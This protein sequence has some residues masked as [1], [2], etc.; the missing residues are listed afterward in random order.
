MQ[1]VARHNFTTVKTE[2]AILPADLLQRIAGGKMEG[3]QPA[4]YHLGP[5]ERL[6]D[7]ITRAW[8]RCQ[9]VW[10]TFNDQRGQLAESDSGLSLTRERW[11]LILFQELGYGRLAYQPRG[12]EVS[13]RSSVIGNQPP[14]TD[15]R[16][17]ITDPRYPISHLWQHTPI[18][19]VS[20]RQ[21]LDRRDPAIKRSPH[22]LM[23][24]FL[25][26]SEDHLWGF[27]SNGLTLQILRDNASLTRAAYVEFD[28]EKMMTEQV[29]ADFTLLWL[30]CHQSR[31]EIRAADGQSPISNLQSPANCWL[32]KWSQ[33]AAEQGTRALD[34]LRIG[35]Q[36]AI[37]ALGRGFLAHPGNETLKRSLRAG[38]LSRDDYFRQ[39]LRLVYRLI[40]L[41]V[42]EE[43]DL[44]LLP[45]ADEPARARY[46]RYYSTGR[47]R[48]LAEAR[49]G[50]PHPD[51][52]RTLRQVFGLLRAGY[53]EL[54]LPA[55][56]SFL[57]SERSTPA[58]DECDLANHDLLNAIRAL[59]LTVEGQ[60]TRPVDYKN[61]GAEELGSV[62]ESLLELHPF[63][64]IEAA[65]FSLD[66][67]AG[68]ERKT[69]GSYY[70]PSSLINSLLDTALEPVVADRLQVAGGKSQVGLA[71]EGAILSIKVV[72]PACGSGHFLMAAA[73]RLATH[74]ARVRTGDGEPS[75]TARREALRDVVHHCIHG[76]DIN[77]MAVELCKVGLWMETLDPGK[78][79]GFLERN[80]QCGNSLIGATPALLRQGIPDAAFTPI[81]GDDTAFCTE[82]K[83]RN[84]KEREG[85]MSMRFGEEPWQRLGD[86]AA[87]MAQLDSMGDRTLDEVRAQE[88][89]Y[90]RMLLSSSYE[91]SHFWADSWC[92]AF[93]WPKNNSFD[94]P[95]TEQ[96]FRKIERDPF[97]VVPWMKM[98][99]RRLRDEYKFFHWH[100]VFPH[101][102]TPRR[103]DPKGSSQNPTGLND[104]GV[105]G[106]TEGFD[107]VLGNPP[108]EKI[109]AEEQ[110]F[111]APESPD[112]A[113]AVGAKRKAMIQK[114][115]KTDPAL[116]HRWQSYQESIKRVDTFFKVSRR[117]PLTGKGKLNTYAVFSELAL[118]IQRGIG[119]AGIII[120]LGIV[121]DYTT[122]DFFWHLMKQKRIKKLIGFE[123]ESFI[124]PDVHHS[125]KFTILIM[126]G[127]ERTEPEPD[128]VFFCRSVDDVRDASRHFRLTADDIE[129]L[130][131]NTHNC[132]IFRSER[133]FRIVQDVY[134]QHPIIDSDRIGGPWG[135]RIHRVV[136]PTDDS[137]MMQEWY[138]VPTRKHIIVEDGEFWAPV[139]EAK[140]IHQFDHRFGS[141]VGQTEAQA[142]QGKLPELTDQEHADPTLYSQPRNWMRTSDSV[143]WLERYTSKNWLMVFRDITSPVVLRTAIAAIIPKVPPVDPCRGIFF[144]S[145]M[146]GDYASCFLAAFNSFAFDFVCRQMFSG[147]HLAIFVL[148]QLVVPAPKS[149]AVH[150]PD[151][152]I[153][154]KWVAIRSLEL[155]YT[156]FD[157][158]PFARDCGYYG[159]PFRWDKERRF[160]LRCELDAAYFHLYGID[161]EDTAYIMDTFPIVRRKDEEA[162]GEYRTKRVILEIFDDM[163]EAIYS[164]TP[165]QTRL[166]PPPADP[167][168][169]HT[170]DE[171]YLGPYCDPSAWWQEVET[172]KDEK[173][174]EGEKAASESP[175]QQQS[176]VS[177]PH[178]IKEPAPAFQLQSPT[179]PTK[180]EETTTP[181]TTHAKQQPLLD[182]APAPTG[183]RPRRLKEA[184]A[185]GKD[186]SPTAT[187]E[188]VAFLADE[189]S[190]IR[191]LAGSSLV[192]RANS[193][194]VTALTAFL[195]RAEPERI[196][197]AKPE[198]QR[199]LGLIAETAESEAVRQ[200]AQY[201]MTKVMG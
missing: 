120:P 29:Y 42:A 87:A 24:E 10:E 152:Q 33:Q 169:A 69:T 89:A 68:S 141:Y 27:V 180:K 11:L 82:W 151:F 28:L 166:D 92:A 31:V 51:L 178:S 145:T 101:V 165:Y 111:F 63:L 14:L 94:Y 159:P 73:N 9:G 192:Q 45:E 188:L 95:I 158:V 108:W 200:A 3:L 65:T 107:V 183:P 23:Q 90:A 174:I 91:D 102:F 146:S 201:T 109:Q 106:W 55:L 53:P 70:T 36:E 15:N 79:L 99:I 190:S 88:M 173:V 75:P 114:L 129:L 81:T 195:D 139:Y 136:N 132:P 57:F 7:A 125:F 172:A 77:E 197:V 149:L 32:E 35:V 2:G 189:D 104:D 113:N 37:T 52:Y 119:S 144:D 118:T 137:T 60:V 150:R 112:I 148:K 59:A 74:L 163:A 84:K 198:I 126:S 13:N 171:S 54:G 103:I 138:P 154:L 115:E 1:T 177:V 122:K 128:F 39:L 175:Y 21:E 71:L 135:V 130:N 20:F 8:T 182:V 170:W 110:S 123:N 157:V 93:V 6:G 161:R 191:W 40:F 156:A 41:F 124:F 46:N 56:G 185:L 67:A 121:T 49:R 22:S 147:T 18:H 117:Y 142:N 194:V 160:L 199:V 83:E 58:L 127:S 64:N 134:K 72:D 38:S 47:L 164:G 143:P 16:S 34:A 167:R 62:Y 4:D 86:L 66:V 133:D 25:S 131:P 5:G 187:R 196:A 43:R 80:I 26:R 85:Q 184:M 181:P 19:L 186:S 48:R 97:D 168:A 76:V 50:G 162:F 105:T 17:P 96:T 140:M 12:L 155:T 44:L 100:L 153:L 98:E 179:P 61:L 193:D 78:P 30:L 116:F 176:A